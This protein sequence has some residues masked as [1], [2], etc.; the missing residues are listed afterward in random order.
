VFHWTPLLLA[1]LASFSIGC[2]STPK[3][4]AEDCPVFSEIEAVR[5]NPA[6]ALDRH[7]RLEAAFK[8]CPPEEGLAEIRRK[9]IEIKHTLIR[10]LSSKTEAEL[11]DPL[12]VENLRHGIH[13]IVNEEVMK[14]GTVEA[15]FITSMELE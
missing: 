4:I 3:Y 11:E 1:T 14:K 12:R 2:A 9:R 15:V 8:V 7:L 13:R 5:V 10:F 6:W